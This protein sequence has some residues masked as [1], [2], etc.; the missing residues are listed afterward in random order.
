[1]HIVVISCKLLKG[2]DIGELPTLFKDSL[3]DVYEELLLQPDNDYTPLED[4]IDTLITC[5][6]EANAQ[7][8]AAITIPLADLLYLLEFSKIHKVGGISSPYASIEWLGV[9]I[10]QV[11]TVKLRDRGLNIFLFN[12]EGA[13]DTATT[14]FSERNPAGRGLDFDEFQEHKADFLRYAVQFH[15]GNPV[16]DITKCPLPPLEE[17][18]RGTSIQL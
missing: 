5:I 9:Q 10:P 1:M 8:V 16:K 6:A 7:D 2:N 11:L 14:Y 18:A 17:I 4:F 3:L 15:Y 12:N 13:H